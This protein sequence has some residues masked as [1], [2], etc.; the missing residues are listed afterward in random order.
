MKRTY[1]ALLAGASFAI[2]ATAASAQD[3]GI[4]DKNNPAPSYSPSAGGGAGS[5]T[6]PK[7]MDSNNPAPNYTPS[8]TGQVPQTSAKIMDGNNPAPN[9]GAPT[10]ATTKTR[11]A[12]SAKSTKVRHAAHHRKHNPTT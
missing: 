11:H 9:Y 6:A 1:L 4:M 2:V 12:S 7:I 5:Q 3:A 8:A 10:T